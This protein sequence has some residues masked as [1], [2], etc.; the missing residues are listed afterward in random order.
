MSEG[1]PTWS[2]SHFHGRNISLVS[3]S[4]K[5]PGGSLPDALIRVKASDT[6]FPTGGSGKSDSGKQVDWLS[7]MGAKYTGENTKV[8]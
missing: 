4:Y 3:M 7:N 8:V 1:H 2:Q 6:N 5:K